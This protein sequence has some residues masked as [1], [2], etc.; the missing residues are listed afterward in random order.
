MRSVQEE[1]MVYESSN[2]S[3]NSYLLAKSQLLSI[4]YLTWVIENVNIGNLTHAAISSACGHFQTCFSMGSM[5]A[6]SGKG[7]I[8]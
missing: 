4:R 7:I 3:D 5:S 8:Q 6:L 1:C 2:L